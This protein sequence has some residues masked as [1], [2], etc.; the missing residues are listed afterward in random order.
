MT[1]LTRV[2]SQ[3]ITPSSPAQYNHYFDITFLVYFFL[4]GLGVTKVSANVECERAISYV[5]DE[6]LKV[7]K[8]K[9]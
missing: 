5:H 2:V 9:K 3:A 4:G 7:L 8:I 6:T 1:V